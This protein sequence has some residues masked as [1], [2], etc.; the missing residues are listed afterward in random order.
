MAIRVIS[1]RLISVASRRTG[2][3][4]FTLAG[5]EWFRRLSTHFLLGGTR[6]VT[7]IMPGYVMPISE[8][9][10][11]I[12]D[13]DG[14]ASYVN[15]GAVN[16]ASGQVLN[17]SDLG[18]GGFEMV[19]RQ[20][21]SSDLA[22]TFLISLTGQSTSA[23]NVANAVPVA[24]IYWFVQSTGAQVANGVALNTKSVRLQIRG[25]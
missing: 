12:I 6:F 8:K 1:K 2:R 22:N 18:I 21:L 10:E 14:P 11:I 25:V 7:R 3:D 5:P 15:T 24:R 4:I 20:D 17:A 13:L 23:D 9:Y 19:D 16:A